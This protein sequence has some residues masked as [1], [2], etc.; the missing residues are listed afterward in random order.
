M[1][2]LFRI[3]HCHAGKRL[4]KALGELVPDLGTRGAKRLLMNGQVTVNKKPGRPF[5]RLKEGDM[6]LLEE[7]KLTGPTEAKLLKKDAPF[8]FL[9][10]PRNLHCA[11]LSGSTTHSLEN[12]LP[13]ILYNHKIP[14]K[15]K[16]LQRL[17][18]GTTGIV[19]ATTDNLGEE[20]FLKAQEEGNC[21]K[22]YLALLTGFLREEI[23]IKNSIATD[24]RKKSKVLPKEAGLLR[25]TIFR[26][27]HIWDNAADLPEKILS[28]LG[29][30]Q[31]LK[32]AENG[33]SLAACSIK[34]G[35]RHQIRAHAAH[36]GF[37][38]VG[39][40]LYASGNSGDANF[41]LHQAYLSFNEHFCIDLPEWLPQALKTSTLNMI[42]EGT[43]FQSL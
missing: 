2:T 11:S 14:C 32:I 43:N 27:V 12:L 41:F 38:L 34:K 37:P 13:Q 36:I 20:E 5:A 17:D 9:F 4:D 33:L 35:A 31:I 1:S 30:E 16:L 22:I 3:D 15:A 19:L 23:I 42:G 29:Q 21:Q 8:L 28:F 39:D 26:P 6:I 10:K 24:K 18:Y 7:N 25:Q 40:K